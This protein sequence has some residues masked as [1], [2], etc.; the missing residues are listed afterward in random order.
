MNGTNQCVTI[1]ETGEFHISLNEIECVLKRG[2]YGSSYEPG[3]VDVVLFEG[4]LMNNTLV[5]GKC[6]VE[7]GADTAKVMQTARYEVFDKYPSLVAFKF[8]KPV[9]L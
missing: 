5:L 1:P 7:H 8:E 4:T 2:L 6:Y 3:T 9:T